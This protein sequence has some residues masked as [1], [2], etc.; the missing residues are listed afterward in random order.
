M[1]RLTKKS[2]PW[3]GENDWDYDSQHEISG[4]IDERYYP[5]IKAELDKCLDKLGML[6]SQVVTFRSTNDYKKVKEWLE[7]K[8]NKNE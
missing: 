5:W 6:E 8:G 7:R 3:F 1:E 4:M 2:K